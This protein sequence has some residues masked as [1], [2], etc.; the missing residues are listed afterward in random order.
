VKSRVCIWVLVPKATVGAKKNPPRMRETPQPPQKA[1]ARNGESLA[2]GARCGRMSLRDFTELQAS[3][4][5]TICRLFSLNKQTAGLFVDA[6]N[7]TGEECSPML[8]ATLLHSSRSR[9]AAHAASLERVE[10]DRHGGYKQ[11]Y[12]QPTVVVCITRPIRFA[13]FRQLLLELVV[14]SIMAERGYNV[15]HMRRA[16]VRIVATP[17]VTLYQVISQAERMQ[18]TLAEYLASDA[19]GGLNEQ[20]KLNSI[21]VVLCSACEGV[22]RL[23]SELK[24]HHGDLKPD[25]IMCRCETAPT[26]RQWCLIDF[27]QA[28]SGD[29]GSDI[30][31]LFWW[32]LHMY[33]KYLP[34]K[35]RA[36]V[37]RSLCVPLDAIRD[38]PFASSV[39]R[40]Q[41]GMVDFA[42]VVPRSSE[43]ISAAPADENWRRQFGI[44]KSELYALQRHISAPKLG[45]LVVNKALHKLYVK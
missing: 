5:P 35:M 32:L 37:A 17:L 31:F 1:E 29:P 33:A 38:V 19:F 3:V 10:S 40:A 16:M 9:F 43:L 15:P 39:V 24:I 11:V 2:S 4:V 21:V 8:R 25:N 26:M 30:F 14:Q 13:T 36:F 20:E 45:P 28:R 6:L 34:R 23:Q 18:H 42:K 22:Y 7:S 12:L 41:S 44:T 27:G